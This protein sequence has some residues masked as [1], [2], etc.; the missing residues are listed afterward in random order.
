VNIK[1][2]IPIASNDPL[3]ITLGEER[4]KIWDTGIQFECLSHGKWVLNN[5]DP[6]PSEE[7]EKIARAFM[8]KG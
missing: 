2:F 6:G 3:I 8:L 7:F 1:G 4:A 5:D